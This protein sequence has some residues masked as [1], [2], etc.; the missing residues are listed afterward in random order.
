MSRR[1]PPVPLIVL[2]I[3]PL[4]VAAQLSQRGII[5]WCSGAVVAITCTCHDAGSVRV[6]C[7]H[8]REASTVRQYPA[9]S[10]ARS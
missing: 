9:L 8:P 7:G 10:V 4:M 6:V 5:V 2:G 1:S 3:L